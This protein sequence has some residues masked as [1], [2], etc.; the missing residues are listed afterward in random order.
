[1]TDKYPPHRQYALKV[2]DKEHI[3]REKKTKYVLIERDTLKTLDGHP[4]IVRLYWTFQDARSLCESPLVLRRFATDW[5]ECRLRTGAREKW[6]AAHVDQKGEL[7]CLCLRIIDL[8]P[9][10][11]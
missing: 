6:R 3:K 5:I 2:L 8:T 10:S 1:V 4:G 7:V 9:T 11:P